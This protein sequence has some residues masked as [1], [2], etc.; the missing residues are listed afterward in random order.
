MPF[1]SPFDFGWHEKVGAACKPP[2]RPNKPLTSGPI[3]GAARAGC[4]PVA[5]ENR[6][7]A[8]DVTIF[9]VQGP[10]ASRRFF[11][12]PQVRSRLDRFSLCMLPGSAVQAPYNGLAMS[13][14]RKPV[15]R[16]LR[17]VD[18]F[19][20]KTGPVHDTLKNLASRLR[21]ENIAY[22]IIGGMAAALHGH[23]RAT[24]D[25]DVLMTS[26]GLDR[27]GKNVRVPGTEAFPSLM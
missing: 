8:K 5:H 21:Q 17:E 9:V 20:V 27:S 26:E 7:S 15:D 14:F 19:F 22:A 25:V 10:P 12:R 11:S 4:A 1:G 24:Q 3:I 16:V 2:E 13:R 6:R 23:V 18:H